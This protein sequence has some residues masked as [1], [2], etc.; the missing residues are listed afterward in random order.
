V[1]KRVTIEWPDLTMSISA[2]LL[3]EKNPELCDVFWSSLPFESIQEHAVVS[4]ESIYCWAPIVTTAPVRTRE[5]LIETPV[6][7]L[8]YSQTTGNKL[9]MR[10]GP[11]TEPLAHTA[12]VCQ[13]LEDDLE[14]LR[15]VGKAV[16][17]STFYTKK[18]IMVHFEKEEIG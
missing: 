9:A 10:Y 4:G 2:T 13:V 18:I 11:V 7:R 14:K 12:P 8:R 3:E 5:K 17:D 16:W 6:G 1:S 15:L